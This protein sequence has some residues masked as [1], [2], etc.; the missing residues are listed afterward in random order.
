MNELLLTLII[1]LG[2]NLA[3]FLPAFIFKTDKLTDFSYSLTFILVSLFA[4]FI[5]SFSV[6]KLILLVMLLAWAFRLGAYLFIR[7][8]KIKK[9]SRFDERRESFWKFLNF[10]LLQG[11]T[12]WIVMIPSINFFYSDISFRTISIV[13]IIVWTT[14]LTIE[15]IADYQK[16]TFKNKYKNKWMESGLF[17]YSRH[18]NY[19]GEVLCWVGVYI[20]T[21][22]FSWMSLLNLVSPLFIL[23]LLLFV[24]GVP[25][26]EKKADKKWGEDKHYQDYKRRTSKFIPWFPKK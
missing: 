20:Y 10:W 1:S 4:F 11:L 25:L 12:V 15:S 23:I 2:I 16:F 13:G 24:S 19:F 8:N 6:A 18:P 7:I 14:G 17:K 9:D 26:L 5:N 3:M 21:L 22:Q